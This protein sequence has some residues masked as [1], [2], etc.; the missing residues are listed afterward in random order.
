MTDTTLAKRPTRPALPPRR[1][2]YIRTSLNR[3]VG[4]E[5]KRVGRMLH[6]RHCKHQHHIRLNLHPIVGVRATSERSFSS[7]ALSINKYML[8]AVGPITH[9]EWHPYLEGTPLL[10]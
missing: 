5:E 7:T 9:N 1:S 3:R 10:V 8:L 6:H 4:G 2:R